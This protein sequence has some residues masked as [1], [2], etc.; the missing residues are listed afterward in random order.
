MFP[1]SPPESPQV[2]FF[3]IVQQLG[4]PHPLTVIGEHAELVSPGKLA[5]AILQAIW[6]EEPS[7]FD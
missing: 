5:G 4:H 1:S 6:D 3:D 2:S 7:P